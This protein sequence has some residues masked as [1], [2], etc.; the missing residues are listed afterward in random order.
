MTHIHSHSH[1]ESVNSSRD[2]LVR[3]FT[4]LNELYIN[5]RDLYN[6]LNVDTDEI[7]QRYHEVERIYG[8]ANGAAND[9]KKSTF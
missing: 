8:R 1:I 7:F 2:Q 6:E 4:K 3:D 5:L 9:L